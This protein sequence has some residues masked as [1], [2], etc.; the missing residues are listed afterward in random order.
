MRWLVAG[1]VVV[2]LGLLAYLWFGPNVR[3]SSGPKA[4][5][6][7][8]AFDFIAAETGMSAEQRDRYAELRDEHQRAIRPLRAELRRRKEILFR[9][10]QSDVVGD[11]VGGVN[12]R[13]V[14][15]IEA[16]ID[17]VT[18][19]HFRRVRALL[20]PEQLRRFDAI[21]MEA[22]RM[23]KPPPEERREKGAPPPE[24]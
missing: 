16:A 24:G 8:R 14:G 2:N 1:L 10:L 12:A 9:G 22:L 4:P 23:M 15:E 18:F 20:A 7:A 21:I 5:N 19:A 3:T 6:G 11:S 13:A 17:S